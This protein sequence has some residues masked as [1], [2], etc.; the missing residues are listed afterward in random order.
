[1]RRE[2]QEVMNM[3]QMPK[4]CEARILAA[5]EQNKKR[6]PRRVG[7]VLLTA[8]VIFAML[9]SAV[10][11]S[12]QLREYIFGAAGP[13][14]PYVRPAESRVVTEDGYE[15]RVDSVIADHYLIV[16]Y[17]EIK[18]LEGNRLQEGMDIWAHFDQ[19]GPDNPG[20]SSSVFGGEIIRCEADGKSALAAVMEWGGQSVGDPN[21]TLRIVKP[22]ECKI[23]VTLEY[24]PIQTIDL[25]GLDTGG[26]L[27]PLDRLELSPLGINAVTQ[28]KEDASFENTRDHDKLRG[29]LTV[30]FEDGS[31]RVSVRDS[32][33]G[34]FRLA[35]GSWLFMD[36]YNLVQPEDV[37]PLDVEQIIGISCQDWYL[38]IENGAAGPLR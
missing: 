4:D 3:V 34:S 31:T 12:S 1:M 6:L 17:L 30:H 10:A 15:L 21:M 23:P 8:A 38:P 5:L 19:N 11:L 37:E 33:G 2:Y 13:F 16:G 35:T 14:A 29:A 7:R 24:V 36:P 25:S 28:Y 27:P 18:D 20:I 26:V 9:T 22:M 32:L